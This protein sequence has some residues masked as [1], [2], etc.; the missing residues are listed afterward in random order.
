[1]MKGHGQMG[2]VTDKLA[3]KEMQK[4]RPLESDHVQADHLAIV[5]LKTIKIKQ[6]E[7]MGLGT[8]RTGVAEGPFPSGPFRRADG[9]RGG[10]SDVPHGCRPHALTGRHD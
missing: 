1:M 3:L 9:G 8:A 2:M 5:D 6:N 4:L 10:L 7:R